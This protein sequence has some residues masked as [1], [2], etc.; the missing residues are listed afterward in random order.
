MYIVSWCCPTGVLIILG[1][2]LFD[3]A[4]RTLLGQV[5]APAS[6]V[7]SLCTSRFIVHKQIAG[8]TTTQVAMHTTVADMVI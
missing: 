8:S 7:A 5:I 4:A 2:Q 3:A 6:M 1:M